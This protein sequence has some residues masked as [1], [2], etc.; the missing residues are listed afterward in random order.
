MLAPT[1]ALPVSAALACEACEDDVGAC[2]VQ[3][4]VRSPLDDE[5]IVRIVVMPGGT[6]S[7]VNGPS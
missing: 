6:P 5:R 1:I 4:A 3:F 2:A 7:Q